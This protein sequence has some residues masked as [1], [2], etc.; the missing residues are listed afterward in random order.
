MGEQRQICRIPSK[1]C[2]YSVLKK[3]K[4]EPLLLK[5]GLHIVTSLQK[6]L[7]GKYRGKK[8]NLEM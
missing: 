3:G 4:Y 8:S 1:F 6:V 2:R 5:C 7:Y